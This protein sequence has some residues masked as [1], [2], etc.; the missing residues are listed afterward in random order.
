MQ[1]DVLV[2][3]KS[4]RRLAPDPPETIAY[5]V[6]GTLEARPGALC[7]RYLEPE[8]TGMEATASVCT[9]QGDE[10]LLERSGGVCARMRFAAGEDG[11][12]VY[13]TP[14]GKLRLSYR[15]TR[16]RRR[17]DA[18]GGVLELVYELCAGG[19]SVGEIQL[20]L[21]VKSIE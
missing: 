6:P 10:L 5:T 7:L 19:A 21:R 4:V 17:M 3:V 2:T 9:L 20:R 1:R 16:L 18:R 11:M 12:T 14:H 13:E 15:T 8:E